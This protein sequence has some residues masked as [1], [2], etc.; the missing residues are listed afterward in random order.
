MIMIQKRLEKQA[1]ELE[2]QVAVLKEDTNRRVE[3]L[4]ESMQKKVE[5][6]EA[7]VREQF[8]FLERA[9]NESA[10][11]IHF[12]KTRMELIR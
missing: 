3:T 1:G 8:D 5:V 11:Q 6:L 10:S 7:E 9:I 12:P 4:E 2:R